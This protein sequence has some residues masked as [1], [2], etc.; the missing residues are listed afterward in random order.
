M[1]NSYVI[2]KDPFT[3]SAYSGYSGSGHGAGDDDADSEMAAP[4]SA[5]PPERTRQKKF[6]KYFKD[7]P[8][9]VA[10][11]R[12]F[13]INHLGYFF[14]DT[15]ICRRNIVCLCWGHSAPWPSLCHRQLH[16]IPFKCL[17]ICHK[18]L[19]ETLKYVSLKNIFLR[20]SFR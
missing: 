4:S 10:T 16:C 19:S 18:G 11:V 14:D 15:M 2:L 20:F 3:G 9:E 17:W 6:S 1:D 12:E 13:V 8:G 7:L 5:N